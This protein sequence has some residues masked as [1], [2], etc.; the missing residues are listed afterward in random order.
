VE[1]LVCINSYH[2]KHYLRKIKLPYAKALCKL[3]LPRIIS[4]LV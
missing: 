4:I 1:A 3:W 2:G